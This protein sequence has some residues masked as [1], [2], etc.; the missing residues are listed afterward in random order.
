MNKIIIDSFAK[1]K[2]LESKNIAIGFFDGIHVG[3]QAL[4]NYMKEN[5]KIPSILTFDIAM[6]SRLKSKS[7]S[8]ILNEK[9]KDEMLSSMGIENEFVLPFNEQIMSMTKDEF[10]E[11]LK[12]GKPSSIVVGDDFTF[13]KNALGKSNDLI[14][15]TKNGISVEIL[16]LLTENNQKISSSNIKNLLKENKI[17]KANEMLG[18]P[19][20][21]KGK[22][23]K[24]LQNGR[25]I[26]FPTANQIYPKDKYKLNPGV[27]KTITTINNKD[28][29]SMT[30]I[31]THPSINELKDDII[32]TH[33]FSFNEYIYEKEIKVS[34]VS[35]IREQKKFNSLDE[36]K[37]QLN[38]DK[39]YIL[40]NQKP[41]SLI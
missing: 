39:K 32:E 13:G 15:L 38:K 31:G 27:Y 22:V 6:K 7:P 12:E 30:N 25:K 35:F 14:S 41:H 26:S 33:I 34:F 24:G 4:I 16:N 5:N 9:E 36:L 29:L 20:F 10:L 1:V 40:E 11:F 3:H 23:I 19:F 18:Y 8:L 21:I 2:L 37:E 28:Y 17:E